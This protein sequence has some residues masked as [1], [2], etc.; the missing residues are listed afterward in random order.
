[1]TNLVGRTLYRLGERLPGRLSTP[2][3]P[4]YAD[5][6]AIWAKPVG[7]APRAVVHCRTAQ[8][9]ALAIRAAC[10]CDLPLSVRGGGHDWA[11]RALCNGIVIDLSGMRSVAVGSDGAARISG[12]AR[13]TDVLA[14]THSLGLAAVTGSVGAVGM[15]G[16][17]LGGG[18]GPL[19]GRFGLAAD[20]LVEAEVV[21][22]DG[23]IV[24]ANDAD[25]AEL[26]WALRGGGGNF[27]VVTAMRCRL[28][29]LTSVRTGLLIYP[30]TEAKAILDSCAE[31]AASAPEELTFQVGLVGG[32]GGAP[33]VMIV[34]T[35]CGA[36]EDGEARLAPFLQLGTLLANTVAATPYAGALTIF[37]PYLVHGQRELMETCWLPAL[38]SGIIDAFIRAMETLVSPGCAV[39]THEFKG[40]ASR[41]PANTTAFGLRRDHVLVEIL[42]TFGDGPDGLAEQPHRQW[43]RATR[44]SFNATALPG[45]YPNLLTADDSD[46]V[47]R[48]YGPNAERLIKAKRR[49]DPDNVFRS[50]IPL[51]ITAGRAGVHDPLVDAAE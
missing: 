27:G 6:T 42:A 47:A 41:V 25:E 19:I 46:R 21:L 9:V 15:A 22:A 44:E 7:H 32:A 5:A 16:L 43:A 36:P 28:H 18:Y 2:G 24:F 13:A 10:D 29:A 14:I 40:A 33:V 3:D 50:A 8:D 35:W 4:G 51:P 31:I 23:R 20:N 11:G 45:G 30:F 26:L 1:M 37:D 38:D 49:Y 48:S 12:G 39:F 17:T 34:P